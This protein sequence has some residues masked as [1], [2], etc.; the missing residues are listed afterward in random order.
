MIEQLRIE[1]KSY[2]TETHEMKKAYE[3]EKKVRHKLKEQIDK[4]LK[5]NKNAYNHK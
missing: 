4:T 3:R 1:I 2:K 5:S